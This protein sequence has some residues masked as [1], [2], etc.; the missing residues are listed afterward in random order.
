MTRRALSFDLRKIGFTACR[1]F[2]CVRVP[3]E[4]TWSPSLGYCRCTSIRISK[5]EAADNWTLVQYRADAPCSARLRDNAPAPWVPESW[6]PLVVKA[7][8]LLSA[9]T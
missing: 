6:A 4:E 8:L 2:D 3:S 9:A 1:S 7:T 5:A